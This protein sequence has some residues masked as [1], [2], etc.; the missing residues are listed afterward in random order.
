MISTQL[1]ELGMAEAATLIRTKCLSPVELTEAHLKRIDAVESRV[2]A[3]VTVTPEAAIKAAKK[4][5]REL[6]N[7]N[8]RGPLHGIP[9]GAKDIICT[10]GLRTSGGSQVAPD[11]VPSTNAAVIERLTDAGAVLLGKTTTTE[12]AYQ[13]GEPPTR[14]PWNL[15]HT[16]GGSSSGSAAAVSAGMAAFTLGTQTFGSLIRPAAYNGLTCMK[17]TFGRISRYGVFYASWTL[18]HIG[19]FTRTVED[20]AITLEALAGWDSRDPATLP[21]EAP[22]FTSGIDRDIRG[23]VVGLPDSFFWQRSLQLQLQWNRRLRC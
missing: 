9:Y 11:Y 18:D 4:A 7:G 2:Q 20:T 8:Y 12:F 16:P 19:C 15:S 13:G 22:R 23:M 1:H 21:G 3:W 5:E 6:M 10:E 14:N 17:P